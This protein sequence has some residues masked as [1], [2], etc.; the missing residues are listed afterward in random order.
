MA[1]LKVVYKAATKNVAKTTLDDLEVK[2]GQQYP[3]VIKSWRNKRKQLSKYFKYPGDV[4]K[5]IYTTNAVET[6]HRQFPKLTKTKGGF[7]NKNSLLKLLY[8]GILKV[9]EK[10]PIQCR[11]GISHCHNWQSISRSGWEEHHDV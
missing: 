2:W 10:G 3:V 5:A 9:S 6:V 1:D 8:T 11:T 7:A 4:R